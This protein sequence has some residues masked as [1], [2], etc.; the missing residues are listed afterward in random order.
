[1]IFRYNARP[2]YENCVQLKKVLEEK[3]GLKV[4]LRYLTNYIADV[5][6]ENKNEIK[7]Q[8]GH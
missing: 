6:Y 5:F 1:M 2:E 7:I 4:P 3:E 8:G